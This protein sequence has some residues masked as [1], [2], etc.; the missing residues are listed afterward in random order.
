MTV[1]PVTFQDRVRGALGGTI[2]GIGRGLH[3]MHVHPDA[4][5]AVG[6]LVVVGA[7][8]LI[9]RGEIQWG[10]IVLI[11]GLP[12][13]ALDGAVARAGNR[14]GKFG[15]VLDSTF[16]RAADALIYGGLAYYFAG[17]GERGN[18]VLSL[19][20]LTGAF[21][22]T[23]ALAQMVLFALDENLATIAPNDNL[24]V[25]TFGINSRQIGIQNQAVRGLV[26]VNRRIEQQTRLFHCGR[27]SRNHRR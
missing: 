6:L 16:D 18:L 21:P 11:L 22:S 23:A 24:K 2:G 27:G 19:A 26:N 20:A 13:D 1:H 10:A 3:R 14:T 7:A 9:G 5:T 17:E 15:G 12:L 8:V 25:Q 4:I